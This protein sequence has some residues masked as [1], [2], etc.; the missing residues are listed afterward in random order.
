MRLTRRT[1]LFRTSAGAAAIGALVA[2]PH[3]LG[4]QST[5]SAA[6]AGGGLTAVSSPTASE[7]PA[8]GPVMA[9]VRDAARGEIAVYVGTR[10]IIRHDPELVSRLLS[11]AL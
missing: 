1:F 7:H 6:T 8:V 2:T 10:E 9:Y 5:V 11:G 3:I 4:T